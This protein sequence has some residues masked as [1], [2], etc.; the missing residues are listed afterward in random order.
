[1]LRVWRQTICSK[2]TKR[3]KAMK[4]YGEIITAE[5]ESLVI[6]VYKEKGDEG[7]PTALTVNAKSDFD[8]NVGDLVAFDMKM[9]PFF[10]STL[11]GYIIPFVFSLCTYLFIKLFTTNIL[12]TQTVFLLSLA[13]C[14]MCASRIADTHFFKK[15]TLCTVTEIIEE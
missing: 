8:C 13:I 12:I 4:K 5:D 9:L 1:M 10:L 6:R 14:Y 2:I 15:I 11:A 3:V 7:V